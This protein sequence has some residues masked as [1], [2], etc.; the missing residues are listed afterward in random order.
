MPR[1]LKTT[2]ILG[3]ASALTLGGAA[4]ANAHGY[5]GGSDS[6]VI[7]RAAIRANNVGAVQYEPQSLE[8][9]GGFPTTG[10]ADGKLASAGGRF[11]GILDEQSP[12]RWI[13]N[14][15]TQGPIT[16]TWTYTAPHR[17]SGWTYYLTK[18]GWDPSAPL[19]RAS[20]ERLSSVQHDGSP[21]QQHSPHTVTIPS[22]R[23]GYH[24]LYAVWDVADS[25]NAFYNA[26]DLLVAPADGEPPEVVEEL[27]PTAPENLR[28]DSVSDTSAR[29]TW[30]TPAQSTELHH[31]E[32]IRDGVSIGTTKQSTFNDANLS[33]DTEYR[34]TVRAVSNSG[35]IGAGAGPIVVRTT[36]QT[37]V[38]PAPDADPTAPTYVHSMGTTSRSVSLMWSAS[39]GTVEHYR[40]ERF[41]PVLGRT[42]VVGTTRGTT[43]VDRSVSPKTAYAYYVTA[44]GA[45]D[46]T[47]RSEAFRVTTPADSNT[48]TPPPTGQPPAWS[49]VGSYRIGDLVSHAGRT[50]QAVQPYRGYGDPNWINAP[51]LW[52]IVG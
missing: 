48:T 10:P 30:M 22:D 24:V 16:I 33:P 38:P 29:L 21:A 36:K 11:G 41:N 27:P 23:E 6:D 37:V 40:V 25:G 46:A 35:L 28:A 52:R 13:K 14:P 17:T 45:K 50:Y 12:T 43:F 19:T 44:V 49:P 8:A 26:I 2:L 51:S 1:L 31:Y 7:A 3:L 4:T 32:V 39:S 47:A 18:A 42:D 5:V 34:Y 9:R 15:V 20:L